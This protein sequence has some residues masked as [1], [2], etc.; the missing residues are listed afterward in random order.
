MILKTMIKQ[1]GKP[2]KSS[3]TTSAIKVMGRKQ[4]NKPLAARL[5]HLMNSGNASKL[6]TGKEPSR[7]L[8][9]SKTSTTAS[10]F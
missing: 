1:S 4:T 5:G 6:R 3:R 9:C 8:R 10:D 7:K 2:W